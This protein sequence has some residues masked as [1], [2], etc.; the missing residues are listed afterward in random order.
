M[1]DTSAVFELSD[2]YNISGNNDNPAGYTG[3]SLLSSLFKTAV[4]DP[5]VAV[6]PPH[7]LTRWKN[8]EQQQTSWVAIQNHLSI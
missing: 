4:L 3:D 7:T 2:V 5:G 6:L 8:E 1:V